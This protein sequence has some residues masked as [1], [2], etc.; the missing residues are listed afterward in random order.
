MLIVIAGLPGTGKTTIAKEV[1]KR[2]GVPLYSIDEDKKRIYK[3]LPEYEHFIK[4]HI[5][6]PDDVRKR[7]FDAS[8]EGLR[9]LAVT[10]RDAIVE[11][12]FHKKKLREPFF[13]EAR[14]IFG[15]IILTL[16]TLDDALVKARL[17]KRTDEEDHMVG[18]GMYQSFKKQWE[19]FDHVD[20]TFVN[21]GN[22]EENIEKYVTFLKNKLFY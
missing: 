1:A 13:E 4:N 5:P 14:K 11:E 16:V 6:F 17:D 8:L 18:Y 21:Q 9:K 10:H 3:Q 20:Y 19:P 2:L 7:T 22:P 15:E 12:T